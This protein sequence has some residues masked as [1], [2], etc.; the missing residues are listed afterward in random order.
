MGR[1]HDSNQRIFNN[2]EQINKMVLAEK[3]DELWKIGSLAEI[4]TQVSP[5]LFA[6]HV[7][8]NLTGNWKE[9]WWF[10]I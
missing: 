6:L 10:S 3:S 4:K 1:K 2:V 9:G 7:Y 5:E 8:V